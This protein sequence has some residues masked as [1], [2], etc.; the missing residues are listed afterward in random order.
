MNQLKKYNRIIAF[1]NIGFLILLMLLFFI[2]S[3]GFSQIPENPVIDSVSVV[4]DHP[5]ISW[6]P[7]TS[8][9]LGYSIYRGRIDSF[10][11]YLIFDSLTSL[12]GIQQNS[13]IDD[14]VSA[15]TEQRLYKVNAFNATNASNWLYA[16]TMTTILITSIDF[17]LCSNS[18]TLEWIKYRNM[19]SQLG[20][21]WVLA[22]ENGRPFSV[23]GTTSAS[24]N[25]YTHS[26]LTANVTYTYKIRAF[27]EN[28]SRTSTS[29]ERAVT[30]QTYAK[31]EMT[32]IAF[33]TVENDEHIKLVWETDG[34]PISK[35]QILRTETGSNFAFLAELEDLVSFSPPTT[36]IDSTADFNAKSYYYSIEVFDFCEKKHL[37]SENIARTIYLS[38]EKT[39]GSEITITWNPYEGWDTGVEKYV[40]YMEVDGVPYPANDPPDELLAT[41]NTYTKDVSGLGGGQGNFS[42]YIKAVE[43]APGNAES[44]SNKITIQLE[45]SI[46]IPNA[47]VAGGDP[48]DNEFKPLV[49]FIEQG[50]YSLTIFNKWGQ[51]L[52]ESKVVAEGWNGTFEGDYVPVGTY[53]YVIKFRDARGA[54]QEKRGTVTVIR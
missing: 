9:T 40:I 43:N 13:Y 3:E 12:N 23:V 10:T 20:G 11:G 29:C 25:Y 22:S 15:C 31:P 47:I 48:P 49:D 8:N 16:D 32:R 18:V 6:I 35:F 28:E 14:Q 42:F 24:Q 30:S 52:F 4:N 33:A 17:D 45:T 5:I 37:T 34:A 54:D 50:Y 36:F 38:G 7:N 39:G 44:F 46:S 41:E 27:N 51:Q 26:N 1:R 53:V 21:Y 19:L 2:S